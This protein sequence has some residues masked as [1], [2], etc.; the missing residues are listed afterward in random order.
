MC[1]ASPRTI[2]E[3]GPGRGALTAL[4]LESGADIH[5]IELD[6]AMV[7]HLR[8]AYPGHPRL[9]LHHTDVLNA[10]LTHWGPVSVAGN[11]PYYITSPILERIFRAHE[12][13]QSATLL[14][15]KEVAERLTARPGSR[16]YAYLSVVT[17]TWMEPHY[18]MTVPP[19][20]FRPPPKVDS[21]VVQ[22]VPHRNTE[23]DTA[24]FLVFCG[25]AFR[26]KRKNLRNNLQPWY[27]AA[28]WSRI[29]EAPLRAEQLSLEQLR[30]LWRKLS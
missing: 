7:D 5:A 2:V 9:K 19:G 29:P 14:I 16:D 24:A 12:A 3:I 26:Q 21:A 30:A 15:Q 6:A 27:P 23:P 13:I 25:R 17:Q 10:D 4:L 28:D 11:L 20:A 22:L 18:L 8:K 1:A